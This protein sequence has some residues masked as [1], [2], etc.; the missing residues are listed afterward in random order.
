MSKPT[1]TQV[2]FRAQAISAVLDAAGTAR[3]AGVDWEKA[4]AVVEAIAAFSV[5]KR[6]G[7]A[8]TLLSYLKPATYIGA[9]GLIAGPPAA[10]YLAGTLAGRVANTV[11]TDSASDI[12][13]QELAAQYQ[14]SADQLAASLARRRA[15]EK[16]RKASRRFG[17]PS[18]PPV[19]GY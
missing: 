2:E 8:S 5:E 9:A 16:N 15:E 7:V 13:E 19:N 11:P 14:Q 3:H 1:P 17:R 18:S 12:L 10:G 4:A 6:A